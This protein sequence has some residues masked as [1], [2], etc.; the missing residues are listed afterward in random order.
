[1]SEMMNDVP[2][3]ALS[4]PLYMAFELGRAE[5]KL[6]FTTG[7]GQRAWERKIVA[8]DQEAL[9]L[10]IRRA[11]HRFGLPENAP[12]IMDITFRRHADTRGIG[13]PAMCT[14]PVRSGQV[15]QRASTETLASSGQSATAL[16]MN[17]PAA[18][19]WRK[20]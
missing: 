12:V 4:G 7:A 20:V 14:I 1:M 13:L 15:P 3:N 6:G 18:A 17:V 5:W 9:H 10:E 11:K 2:A 16:T 19:L 8:G